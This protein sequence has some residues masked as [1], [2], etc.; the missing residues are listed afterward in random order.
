MKKY[1]GLTLAVILSSSAF[2]QIK[3]N[4]FATRIKFDQ[5]NMSDFWQTEVTEIKD[6]SGYFLTNRKDGSGFNPS[7]VKLDVD[8]NIV[9]DTI[10]DMVPNNLGGFLNFQ[11]AI[12]KTDNHTMLYATGSLQSQ[13][14]LA[15]PYVINVDTTGSINWQV[16]YYH[17]TLD[18]EARKII[19]TQD[20]GYLVCGTLYD[21]MNSI[22]VPSGFAM[23]L[24]SVGAMQ[25]QS[26]YGEKDSMEIHFNAGI[27]TPD[28]G[29]LFVGDAPNFQGGAKPPVPG[30]FDILIDLVRTDNLGN[31]VWSKAMNLD[32]PIDPMY[33]FG[34]FSVAMLNDTNAFVSYSVYD[35]TAGGNNKFAITSLNVNTGVNNWTKVYSLAAGGHISLRKAIASKNGDIIVTASDY[36]GNGTGV[37]FIIDAN[38][39]FNQTKRFTY[40]NNSNFPYNTINTL[41]GGVVHVSEVAPNEVLVVKTDKLFDPSCPNI[42]SLYGGLTSSIIADSSFFGV[43]DTTYV[44]GNVNTTFL[45]V[46]S[47]VVTSADDSLICSCSNMISGNVM[48]GSTPVNNAHVFLFRKGIVPKPWSPIDSVHTDVTGAYSFN[49]VP[50]DSFL[51]KVEPD[52]LFNPNSM[53]SYHKHL[54]TCYKW[55]SAG[56][57]HVHC[58]SGSV[59]KDVALIT[60]PPLTGGSSLNGYIFENTGSFSKVPGDPIPGID[61]TVEQ[62]PGGIIGGGTSDGNGYYDLQNINANA[63]YIVSIDCPGLP[64]DSIWTVAI[65]LNDS[66]L[67]SLNFYIDSTGIYI[68]DGGI[69][70]VNIVNNDPIEFEVYPNPSSNN[71]NLQISAIKPED[72]QL[73]IMNELGQTVF[74]KQENLNSGTNTIILN[75]EE[76]SQGLY[77]LKIKQKNSIYFKKLVKQ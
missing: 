37:I 41:D 62:S 43:I 3:Y 72:V 52:P 44:L 35:T 46:G 39:N 56:V 40:A 47:P 53:I 7:L 68:I 50:S 19:P 61:I 66:T 17:D 6:N 25:W 1:I 24:N 14:S 5:F 36:N 9:F 4:K 11:N 48:D 70:G 22:Y 32:N 29:F 76:Y 55:E 31:V 8:G 30:N 27:E 77:L 16:G 15:A 13:M 2:A 57:F 60:P 42:D 28:G 34:D 54:D 10:Y 67:D 23:K 18:L 65:N 12:T 58:D 49:Y 59:V 33:G 26:I 21:W 74:S 75:T 69:T 64:H 71:F 20:G 63:T 73:E 51:V 38:G 45:P